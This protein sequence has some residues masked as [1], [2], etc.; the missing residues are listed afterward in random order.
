MR[1]FRES[2]TPP[3]SLVVDLFAGPGG[4]DE[5]LK[6]IAPHLRPVGIELDPNAC[7]TA[8]AAGHTRLQSDVRDAFPLMPTTEDVLGV[9]AS[10]PCPGFSPAG[11]RKGHGDLPVMLYWLSKV[12]GRESFRTAF[13]ALMAHG[14][15][16]PRSLLALEP[17]KWA[18]ELRPRWTAWEQV[19]K[20]QPLWDECARILEEAGYHVAT[21]V[22]SSERYGVPQTRKRSIFIA[23]QD[24][25]GLSLPTP[26][27]KA[28]GAPWGSLPAAVS[29][30]DALGWDETDLVGFPRK[31]VQDLVN[32]IREGVTINGQEYRARDLRPASAPS[33]AITEKARS[34]THFAGAGRTSQKTSGQRPRIT[35]SEP[36]HTI[37][38]KGTATF[39]DGAEARQV[40]VW[41]AGVLQTFPKEYPWSGSRS[42]QFLQVGNAI[43]P[44]M[45]EAILGQL[46]RR[47]L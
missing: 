11:L 33:F 24:I 22:M 10:P 40:D 1:T 45:A 25:E 2:L 41:E 43:P 6:A 5:G 28:Y 3:P 20:V 34:W 29:I 31:L 46:V 18:L 9:I 12:H 23:S 39:L 27:R 13:A 15:Q 7:A 36:A 32:G 4:W 16:D 38:G 42:S 17:L 26:T 8:R 44:K 37:T 14:M 30:A 47:Q 35:A 21:G 19:E